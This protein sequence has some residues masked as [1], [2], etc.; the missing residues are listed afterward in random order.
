MHKW[1]PRLLTAG[2]E[3]SRKG[4]KEKEPKNPKPNT[5]KGDSAE[6]DGTQIVFFLF[7]PR[8]KGSHLFNFTERYWSFLEL[9]LQPTSS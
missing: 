7:L 5:K 9:K 1:Q 6:S 8:R 2:Q 3:K 4:P